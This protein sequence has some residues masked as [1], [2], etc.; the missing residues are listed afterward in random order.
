MYHVYILR[1]L[2]DRN[3]YIGC[4]KKGVDVR[5]AE[6]NS[7][8]TPSLKHRRPLE[9][10]YVESYSNQA[11]AYRREREIKRYKSGI[12]FKKLIEGSVA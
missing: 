11:D 7:G 1:S 4:T 2:V 3:Y 6:H 8:K 12:G 5:L 9:I 10:I